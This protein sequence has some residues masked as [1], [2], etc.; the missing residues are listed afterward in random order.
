MIEINYI[1]LAG[2]TVG[3]VEA[4]KQL[5]LPTKFAPLVAIGIGIGLSFL[6]FSS[7]PFNQLILFGIYL[8]LTAVGLYSGT[9]NTVEGVRDYLR[10]K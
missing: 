10:K 4:V 1:L 5:G 2:L 7:L 6:G 9:K 8:G 3:L